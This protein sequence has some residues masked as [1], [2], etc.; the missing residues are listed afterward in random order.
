MLSSAIPALLVGMGSSIVLLAVVIIAN[1]WQKYLW[2]TL[3]EAF[4]ATGTTW[5][6]SSSFSRSPERQ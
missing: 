3:P 4:G 5:C 1:L 2:E 6:G